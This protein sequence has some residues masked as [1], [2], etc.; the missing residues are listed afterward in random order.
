MEYECK[1]MHGKFLQWVCRCRLCRVEQSRRNERARCIE[2]TQDPPGCLCIMMHPH[3][4][5]T[6]YSVLHAKGIDSLETVFRVAMQCGTGWRSRKAIN[7]IPQQNCWLSPPAATTREK[8][9]RPT[10]RIWH[11]CYAVKLSNKVLCMSCKCR[12]RSMIY[13]TH[14]LYAP[15]VLR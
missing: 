1:G 11:I 8:I 2:K 3:L 7:N 9:W 15:W 10:P 12:C 5:S 4:E 6:D 13:I 14:F